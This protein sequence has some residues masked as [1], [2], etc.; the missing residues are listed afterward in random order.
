MNKRMSK[1][2]LDEIAGFFTV[3]DDYDQELL[4]GIKAE[5]E[6]VELIEKQVDKIRYA[7][8]QSIELYNVI[9][10][11]KM[12]DAESGEFIALEQP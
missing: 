1:E 6:V 10:L 11:L 7:G 2:R 12:F 4:E 8:S 3:G 9:E 5:R